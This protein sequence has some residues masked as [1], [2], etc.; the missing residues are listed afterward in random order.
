[1]FELQVVRAV[2]LAHR[3]FVEQLVELGGV[4]LLLACPRW[5]INLV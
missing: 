1:M 5:V 3:V 4:Q 2:L